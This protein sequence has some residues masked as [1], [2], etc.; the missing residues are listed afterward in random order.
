MRNEAFT[1]WAYLQIEA[2]GKQGQLVN[3]VMETNQYKKKKKKSEKNEQSFSNL[4]CIMH[5]NTH[6]WSPR[7]R[8]QSGKITEKTLS[9]GKS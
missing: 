9:L 6:K 5:T 7:E 8:E 4:K 2:R 1:E 3:T